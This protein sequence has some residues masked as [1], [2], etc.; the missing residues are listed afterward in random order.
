MHEVDAIGVC[1]KAAEYT[2]GRRH[3]VQCDR[4]EGEY[5]YF[6][7]LLL[8]GVPPYAAAYNLKAPGIYGAYALILAAFG[9][10]TTAIHLGLIVVTSL[11]LLLYM[12]YH[13]ISWKVEANR[14]TPVWP[15]V[16]LAAGLRGQLF[17]DRGAIS[18]A[19]HDVLLG[20]GLELL[21]KIRKHMQNRVIRLWDTLLLRKRALIETMNDQLKNISQ[22][23]HTRHRS[24]PGFMVNV[25]AGLIVYSHRPK[26]PSLSLRRDP[27]VPMLVT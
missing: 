3:P 1:G 8:E 25:V 7:Q 5:A 22:I 17:G 14:L 2:V 20:Q 9:Q 15:V 4:D 19:L 13:A 12:L 21:T 23:E 24:V 10:T 16:S 6:G 11:P 26:K 18:Q 27:L